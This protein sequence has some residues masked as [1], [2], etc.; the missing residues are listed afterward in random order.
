MACSIHI[1]VPASVHIC[2]VRIC[3]V[4]SC[5]AFAGRGREGGICQD[6]ND[7]I[8]DWYDRVCPY[9]V[10]NKCPQVPRTCREIV[11]GRGSDSGC[12]NPDLTNCGRYLPLLPEGDNFEG[13]I[14]NFK[15]S[16]Y[17]ESKRYLFVGT[18]CCSICGNIH[19]CACVV[20]SGYRGVGLCLCACVFVRG[21]CVSL[22]LLSISHSQLARA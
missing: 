3:A 8:L 14:D 15:L 18:H 13:E 1:C 9:G 12:T 20:T 2:C 10:G 6:R 11:C 4:N 17:S 19:S 22:T 16:D 7:Q 21:R 5:L